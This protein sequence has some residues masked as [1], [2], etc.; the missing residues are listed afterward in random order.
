MG[1]RLICFQECWLDWVVDT[2]GRACTKY[3]TLAHLL[4]YV[5][6]GLVLDTG[7]EVLVHCAGAQ[8]SVQPEVDTI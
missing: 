3:G 5:D 2:I 6:K 1:E 7:E 4:S 8:S